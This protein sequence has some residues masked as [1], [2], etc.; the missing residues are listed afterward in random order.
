[1]EKILEFMQP[2]SFI[3]VNDFSGWGDEALPTGFCWGKGGQEE[4]WL[5][6]PDGASLMLQS[7]TLWRGNHLEVSLR[8]NGK[9]I[10][11]VKLGDF[12]PEQDVVIA[13]S[14]ESLLF[15]AP[16]CRTKRELIRFLGRIGDF[17]EKHEM[18]NYLDEA[19]DLAMW[20]YHHNPN[21]VQE[22]DWGI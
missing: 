20:L 9:E 19:E 21:R 3:F 2:G 1:M 22:K 14:G 8:R 13:T 7:T 15:F 17:C 16:V 6:D 4:N 10:E 5:L 12:F 11:R 18:R